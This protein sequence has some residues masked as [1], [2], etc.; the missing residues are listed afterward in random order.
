M[1]GGA[2]LAGAY[3][4]NAYQDLPTFH[5]FDPDLTSVIYDRYGNKVYELA[6]DEH[7]TLV[8]L[9]DIPVDVRNAVIAVEDRRFYQHFGIDP[10]RLAG[11]VWSD[12]KYVL[13]VPGG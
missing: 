1:I 9:E 13:G 3:V 5:E 10:I 4:Y 2:G 11:A 7:R 12:I 6:M 8:E